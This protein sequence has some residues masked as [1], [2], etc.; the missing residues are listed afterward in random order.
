[1]CVHNIILSF[2]WYIAL[3]K[4]D[5]NLKTLK[6]MISEDTENKPPEDVP[7]IK[8]KRLWDIT[9]VVRRTHALHK[10]QFPRHQEHKNPDSVA[11]ITLIEIPNKK[12]K[13]LESVG[14][15]NFD[16]SCFNHKMGSHGI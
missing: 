3:V 10:N 9:T 4:P 5:A 15:S 2:L 7:I 6:K 8:K 16:G 11:R 1:M 14:C 12:C 13:R